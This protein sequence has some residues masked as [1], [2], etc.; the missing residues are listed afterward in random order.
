MWPKRNWNDRID[1]SHWH[2][3]SVVPSSQFRL[4]FH[5]IYV[6][7]LLK[8]G[9]CDSLLPRRHQFVQ[10]LGG[11]QSRE[12][13]SEVWEI[14]EI[15]RERW[16]GF[17]SLSEET[18]L[19]REAFGYG[20]FCH[21]AETIYRFME[22]TNKSITL[23]L[24]NEAKLFANAFGCLTPPESLDLHLYTH[25]TASDFQWI[26]MTIDFWAVIRNF[27]D[28]L[29][30]KWLIDWVEYTG[31]VDLSRLPSICYFLFANSETGRGICS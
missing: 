31:M 23:I 3:C 21:F 13:E 22:G 14:C 18:E 1:L 5:I 9:K 28:C 8:Q 10:R 4:P 7:F 12:D 17:W 30:W 27:G 6:E 2:G 16:C 25:V 26:W 20:R 29:P 24:R 19:D 15:R 11:G